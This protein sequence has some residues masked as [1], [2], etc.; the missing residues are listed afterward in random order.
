MRLLLQHSKLLQVRNDTRGY[1][2]EI[3][4]LFHWEGVGDYT[5]GF[6]WDSVVVCL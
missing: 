1:D 5:G 2:V 4:E 3:F 6:D